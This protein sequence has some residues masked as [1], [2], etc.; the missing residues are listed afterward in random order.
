M[1]EL[2]YCLNCLFYYLIRSGFIICLVCGLKFGGI[3]LGD[4]GSQN[5]NAF[6]KLK[7]QFDRFKVR[8][9]RILKNQIGML[10]VI[11]LFLRLGR[12]I[13]SKDFRL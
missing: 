8:W 4:K 12:L 7:I 11:I 3:L 1:L 2:E 5:L 13:L 9:I 6:D 10:V